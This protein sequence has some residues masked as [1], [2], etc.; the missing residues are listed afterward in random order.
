LTDICDVVGPISTAYAVES[1]HSIVGQSPEEG[2]DSIASRFGSGPS[3]IRP[4]Y[5]RRV[6]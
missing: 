6:K 1:F 2:F 4:T 3:K 5:L